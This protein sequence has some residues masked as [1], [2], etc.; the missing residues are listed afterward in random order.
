ML[1]KFCSVRKMSSGQQHRHSSSSSR[2]P[3]RSRNRPQDN[4]AQAAETKGDSFS[5]LLEEKE[6][7]VR[8][9]KVSVAPQSMLSVL[10]EAVVEHCK[11][12]PGFQGAHDIMLENEKGERLFSAM[13]AAEAHLHHGSVVTWTCRDRSKEAK[14]EIQPIETERAK[15]ARLEAMFGD[16]HIVDPCD[17]LEGRQNLNGL[18]VSVVE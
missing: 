6:D 2:S 12:R 3:A 9:M 18:K 11:A 17:G 7:T 16:G 10:Q 13:T 8:P 5:V 14:K 1:Y 4:A 15:R